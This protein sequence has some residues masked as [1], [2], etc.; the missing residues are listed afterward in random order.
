MKLLEQVIKVTTVYESGPDLAQ[1]DLCLSV[2]FSEIS[3]NV[4]RNDNLQFRK[5]L[6]DVSTNL[7]PVIAKY[8]IKYL[9]YLAIIIN[10]VFFILGKCQKAVIYC[11]IM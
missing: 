2:V 5:S 1:P 3:Q 9:L 8:V 10:K 6:L 11:L 4:L 7:L